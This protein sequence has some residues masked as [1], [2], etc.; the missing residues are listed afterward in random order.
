MDNLLKQIDAA[1]DLTADSRGTEGLR[2]RFDRV[3]RRRNEQGDRLGWRYAVRP[4]ASKDLPF[5]ES[6]YHPLYLAVKEFDPMAAEALRIEHAKLHLAW[7]RYRETV[8]DLQAHL[9]AAQALSETREGEHSRVRD[10]VEAAI[11]KATEALREERV[12]AEKALLETHRRAAKACADAGRPYN[13]EAPSPEAV[14]AVRKATEGEIADR[15][16]L[17]TDADQPLR[18]SSKVLLG[19]GKV[20]VG[21][22]VGVSLAFVLNMIPARTDQV[23]VSV[24]VP[25]AIGGAIVAFAGTVAHQAWRVAAQATYAERNVRILRSSHLAAIALVAAVGA[26][27]MALEYYGMSHLSAR[28]NS[29]AEASQVAQ[30]AEWI[31]WVV[32]GIVTPPV[33][34]AEALFGYIEGRWR[35]VSVALAAR[36]T[37]E[38]DARAEAWRMEPR[39]V[40]AVASV[41]D[42]LAQLRALQAVDAGIAKV[43]APWRARLAESVARRIARPDDFEERAGLLIQQAEDQ[44]VEAQTSVDSLRDRL[45]LSYEKRAPMLAKLR[46][47][48]RPGRRAAKAKER[49]R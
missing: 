12:V 25:V 11:L 35:S 47:G 33:L 21:A 45:A 16:D 19:L 43:E 30:T 18:T 44:L 10:E 41:N 27:E 24:L 3:A 38:H 9:S 28:N 5:E 2:A 49:V 36:V 42:V 1:S 46:W 48:F 23:G 17:P 20:I 14:L 32:G 4:S 34:I 29:G 7:G 40:I 31:F 22:V 6:E 26:F 8:D 39:T 37:A 15:D 13:P